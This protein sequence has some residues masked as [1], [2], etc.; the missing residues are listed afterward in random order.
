MELRQLRYF[1]AVARH[2]HFTRAAD[3]LHVTQSALSQQVRRLEEELGV[4]LLLRAPAGVALTPAGEDL[5]ARADAILA[6]AARAHADMDAHAGLLRGVVRIAA[7]AA[8]ALALPPALAAF[9]RAHPGIRIGLRQSAPS[10]IAALVRTGAVDLGVASLP[11]SDVPDGVRAVP[12]A[13]E[14][15]HAIAPPGDPLAAVGEVAV[16]ELR[17]RPFILAEQGSA[18]RDVVAAACEAAGFGPVPLFEVGDPAAV[19][20]LVHEGLGVSLVPASWLA[21]PGAAVAVARLAAPAPR[22]RALLLAPAAG[23]PPAGELLRAEL[24]AALG[25]SEQL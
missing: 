24:G 18:L 19:R 22:H 9:H 6:E 20:D 5:L 1:T 10:A 8:A 2:R 4:E 7:D 23:A 17:E 12:L 13:D 14:P 25:G 3:E 21:R 11:A 15:L 16:W